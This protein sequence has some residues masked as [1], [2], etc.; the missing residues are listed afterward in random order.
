M[1]RTITLITLVSN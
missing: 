1:V